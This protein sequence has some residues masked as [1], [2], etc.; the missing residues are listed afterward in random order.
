MFPTLFFIAHSSPVHLWAQA[1]SCSEALLAPGRVSRTLG[2]LGGLLCTIFVSILAGLVTDA[3]FFPAQVLLEV[4]EKVPL[5][6]KL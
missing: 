2:R 4:I 6:A 1:G 3:S 5:I